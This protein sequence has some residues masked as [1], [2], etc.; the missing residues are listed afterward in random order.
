MQRK[1]GIP[2][3]L[4]SLLLWVQLFSPPASSRTHSPLLCWRQPL[5]VVIASFPSQS[6]PGGCPYS[7]PSSQR[8]SGLRICL[9]LC[10]ILQL[11][12]L[13]GPSPTIVPL[14]PHTESLLPGV[15]VLSWGNLDYSTH[16]PFSLQNYF[17]FLQHFHV[18]LLDII[19]VLLIGYRLQTKVS[20]LLTSLLLL[21]V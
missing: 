21:E 7:L 17:W 15:V 4:H 12:L 10:L 1:K 14:I 16:S 20:L 18:K 13:G 2:G 3:C 6:P 9:V 8:V 19:Y 5:S 11:P